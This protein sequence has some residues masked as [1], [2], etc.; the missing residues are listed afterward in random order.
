MKPRINL[1]ILLLIMSSSVVAQ[2]PN[3]VF[4]KFS[5]PYFGQKPPG[6]KAEPFVPSIFSKYLELHTTIAFSPDGKEAFWHALTNGKNSGEYDSFIFTSKTVNGIWITPEI[7]PFSLINHSDDSPF[8]STDGNIIYFITARKSKELP[9]NSGEKIWYTQKTIQGWSEP[10]PV[11]SELNSLEGIHWQISADKNGSLYF[12]VSEKSGSNR[13]LSIYCSKK[14]N[15]IYKNTEKLSSS[16]N[17]N[18]THNFS[19]F[20]SPDGSYILFCRNESNISRMFIS[21]LKEDGSW[22]NAI[23]INHII[24]MEGQNINTIC[25]IVTIDGKYLFFVCDSEIKQ[26]YWVDASFIEDLREDMNK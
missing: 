23:S 22:T 20:I 14:V 1:I 26:F 5:G 25:P 2:Q 12:G 21:F 9:N 24:K 3:T 17:K 11:P 13:F 6:K 19:P 8:V 7:A 16:I 15:G 4:S 10:K 18:G